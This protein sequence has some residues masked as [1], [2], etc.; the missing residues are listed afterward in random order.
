M[1][2]KKIKIDV[3]TTTKIMGMK[4]Y[5]P[6]NYFI[7]LSNN[8]YFLTK[9]NDVK[10]FTIFDQVSYDVVDT[11]KSCIININEKE[12]AVFAFN[13]YKGENETF[14]AFI[15]IYQFI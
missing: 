7:C 14:S 10:Y 8:H 4:D 13:F 5:Y 11:R 9:E 15:D 2:N 6:D 3:P 12:F 1:K